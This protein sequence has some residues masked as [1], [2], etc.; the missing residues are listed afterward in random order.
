MC[1]YIK[2]TLFILFGHKKNTASIS[3]NWIIHL[4]IQYVYSTIII[5]KY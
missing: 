5:Y 3:F 2:M 4:P 1:F